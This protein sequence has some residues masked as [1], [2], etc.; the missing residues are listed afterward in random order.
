MKLEAIIQPTLQYSHNTF[1]AYNSTCQLTGAIMSTRSRTSFLL[2]AVCSILLASSAS[3]L[4]GTQGR[5]CRLHR[6]P[7]QP[8]DI[9]HCLLLVRTLHIS[10]KQLV[11]RSQTHVYKNTFCLL[12][13]LAINHL[14]YGS[15]PHYG[16]YSSGI[17]DSALGA[18]SLVCY[19]NPFVIFPQRG[20]THILSN[21]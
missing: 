5:L 12:A 13:F 3:W 6:L 17:I 9:I 15:Y 2:E 11:S 8:C 4:S 14:M 16:I 19:H 7:S 10:S 21:T 20:H 18:L 1:E